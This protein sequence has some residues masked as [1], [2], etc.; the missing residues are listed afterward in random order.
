VARTQAALARLGDADRSGREAPAFPAWTRRPF[1]GLNPGKAAERPHPF[2]Q[3][4]RR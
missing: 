4:H 2:A 1:G 3:G